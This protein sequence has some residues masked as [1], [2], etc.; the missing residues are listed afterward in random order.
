M[1]RLLVDRT[2]ARYRYANRLTFVALLLPALLVPSFAH[3]AYAQEAEWIWSPEHEKT[4]VPLGSCY[5]RKNFK[6]KNP[7]EATITLAADDSYE[8]FLNGRLIGQGKG[9]R[10]LDQIDVS[11]L[12][13]SGTN[14]L[15]LRIRNQKGS[16]AAVAARVMVKE[17]GED[18]TSFSTDDSWKTNLRPFPLWQTS[19]YNDFGWKTAQTFGKLGETAPWDQDNATAQEPEAEEAELDQPESFQVRRE[20]RVERI[21]D[22]ADYDSA[23]L[24]AFTF[25]EFGRIIASVE[26]GPLLLLSSEEPDSPLHKVSIY[27]DQVTNCQ[28][29]LA[30]NGSV[31]VTGDGPDGQALYRLSDKDRNGTMETVKT[32]IPMR[33]ENVEHGPHGVTLGPDGLLYLVVGNLTDTDRP[34]DTDSPYHDYY[35]GDLIQ[36]RYEDPNG[37]AAGVQ[38]PG[39]VV[40]RTDVDGSSVQVVAGGLRNAYDLTF[41]QLGDLFVQDSDLEADQGMTWYRP[42]SLYHVTAGSEFGWRSGWAKWPEHFV[43]RLPSVLETGRGSPTGA[44]TYSHYMFPEKYHNSIFLADW[45][46][47]RILSIR[48]KQQG[49]SY[50]ANSEVFLE[51]TPLNVTDLDVGPEGGLY[52][53]TGGRGTRGAIY[54]VTWKGKVPSSVTNLGEGIAAA[55]RQP[56]LQ[57]A[58]GR[59]KIA[60]IQ[61]EMGEE[62]DLRIE[63]VTRSN[64]NPWYYRTRAL[65]IMQ[66][67]GPPPSTELL[68][69]LSEEESELVRA[70]AVDLMG[71][72]ADETTKQRLIELL[73][74]PDRMV[75]RKVCEAL[76][77]ATQSPPLESLLPLLASDDRFESW[78]ARRLLERMPTETWRDEILETDDHRSFVQGAVALMTSQPNNDNALAILQRFSALMED[79]IS[80][81]DFVAMLRVIQLALMRSDLQVEDYATFR[82]NLA[83]EFPAGNHTMNRE[84]VRLLVYMQTD[85]ILDR[86]FTFLESDAPDMEKMHLAM[87]LR[88]LK[89]GWTQDQKLLLLEQFDRIQET[90]QGSSYTL[91][92][93]N[94]VQD[95]AE[96]LTLDESLAVLNRGPDWPNAALGALA[97]LPTELTAEQRDTLKDLDRKIESKPA[98]AFTRLRAGIVAVMAESGDEDSMTFLRKQW[99]RY[100]D[101]RDTIAMGLAQQPEGKNWPYLIRSIPLL[102]SLSGKEV[103][104]A[105]QNVQQ[106]PQEPQHLR[107]VIL[108]GLRLGEDGAAEAAQLLSF[109][110]GER[111]TENDQTWQESMRA[112]QQWFATNHPELE[113]AE[114]PKESNTAR[115]KFTETLEFLASESGQSGS[116]KR[117]A[118]AFGKAQCSKCHRVGNKGETLGPDLTSLAKRYTTREVLESTLFPSHVI[119]PQYASKT[120]VMSDGLSYSGMLSP[121]SN[122]QRVLLRNDGKK[123]PLPVEDIEE[124]LPSKKSSMPTGLL[125]TLTLRE[126]SDLFAFLMNKRQ[127]AVAGTVSDIEIK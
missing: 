45:A 103:L 19:I 35:E 93:L 75:R 10:Q 80:D 97:Q 49:S 9:I 108:C 46:S 84:L 57:S 2:R 102:S 95:I 115:W 51:G 4:K 62:W 83:E 86:F 66:L 69:E 37:H 72:H 27:C 117:G 82:E 124:I 64:E 96:N 17:D 3:Q 52:F 73:D 29:I 120:I 43:D 111:L 98:A 89:T 71:L 25:D 122:G 123:I 90:E 104:D 28:G 20:F 100:P 99:R 48:F 92:A 31:F 47:G 54:R 56:Q 91:Y 26:N 34:Y 110:T 94:V 42:P 63:S 127:P 85:S 55:I 30:L 53:A 18:W 50:T 70:K 1:T 107:Q 33:G 24:I 14:T 65:D 44:V 21:F 68:V 6:V 114:L 41:N 12:V 101:R 67:Y 59:Q 126:V 5:F 79:F 58:W 13:K 118:A 23:S 22:G 39:G 81:Q 11:K 119:S 15:A 40:L 16:T 109:W 60:R 87:H 77:R 116:S 38:A 121:E 88:F 76:L 32:L 125:D 78:A 7:S 106:R 113:P 61:R 74:D 36:P 105:L 112:W 8:L